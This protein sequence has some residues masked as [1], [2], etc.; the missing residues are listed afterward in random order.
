MKRPSLNTYID[1]A[2]IQIIPIPDLRHYTT[3]Y[4]LQPM[5]TYFA[6]SYA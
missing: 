5:D 1:L 3:T 2:Y 4:M 6:Q